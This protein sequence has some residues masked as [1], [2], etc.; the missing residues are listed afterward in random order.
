MFVHEVDIVMRGRESDSDDGV[1]VFSSGDLRCICCC[2]LALENGWVYIFL[3]R[4]IV[5]LTC[6]N[7]HKIDMHSVSYASCALLMPCEWR[8]TLGGGPDRE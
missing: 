3:G 1:Y 4:F 5:K 2:L 8:E 7:D 6:L